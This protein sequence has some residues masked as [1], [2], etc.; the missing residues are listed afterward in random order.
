MSKPLLDIIRSRSQPLAPVPTGADSPTETDRLA[1]IRAV[2]WDVYGTLFISGSGDIG[3]AARFDGEAAIREALTS[4][5]CEVRQPEMRLHS[6]FIELIKE[7]HERLGSGG[8]DYPEVEI[9]EIWTRLVEELQAVGAIHFSIAPDLDALAVAFEC[10]TNPV[11]PMPATLDCL[12]QLRQQGVRLGIISNSQFYTPLLFEALLRRPVEE[13]G[14]DPGLCV[15]S[16]R[17]RR[18]KPDPSLFVAAL[19]QLRKDGISSNQTLFVGNDMLNDIKPAQALGMKTA[20]FAGDRRSLRWRRD[21]PR[22]AKTTP[23]LTLTR[24][25]QLPDILL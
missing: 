19:D 20:L 4:A 16:Y 10:A 1:G 15:W 12:T 21:D 9:R 7:E 18:G 13:I 17:L 25:D 6:R 23:D 2:L 8:V 24:L 14:F 5:G 3:H 22:V 11:W